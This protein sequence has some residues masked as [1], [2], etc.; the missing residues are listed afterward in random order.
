[1][2]EPDVLS[3]RERLALAATATCGGLLLNG[4][5]LYALLAR[6]D[7]RALALR[8]PVAWALLGDALLVT[9]VLAW[10]LTRWGV[11]R[12]GPRWFWALSLAGGLG[13]SVPFVL[14]VSAVRAGRPR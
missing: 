8:D 12:L 2:P 4:W 11:H 6:P 9:G 13:F 5:F 7:L 10:A 14:L 1:M 3:A